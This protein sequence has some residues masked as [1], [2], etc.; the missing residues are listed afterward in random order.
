MNIICISSKDFTG[1]FSAA[2]TGLCDVYNRY[3]IYYKKS[4]KYSPHLILRTACIVFS[5]LILQSHYKVW[6][7]EE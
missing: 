3:K 7:D 4:L 6:G 1:I 2:S 5:F